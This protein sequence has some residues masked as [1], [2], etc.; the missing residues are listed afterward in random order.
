[1]AKF[2]R[3]STLAQKTH[4]A[5]VPLFDTCQSQIAGMLIGEAEN[6]ADSLEAAEWPPFCIASEENTP[7]PFHDAQ[8]IAFESERRIIALIAGSQGGKTAWGPWW[9]K[10][11]I[12]RRGKGDYI[13]AT[14]SYDLFKLKML[15]EFLRVFEEIL[16]LGRFWAGDKVFELK[17]PE[18]GRY[19]ANKS[20]D[21][22]WGRVIL[23]SANAVGGLESATVKGM[24]LDEAGQDD[25][26]IDAWH[27][28]RRRGTIHQAR[29]LITT[30]LYN[31]GWLKQQVIDRAVQNG[32][33]TMTEVGGG[34]IEV[35]DNEQA[36]ICLTQFD[37]IVNPQFPISE[38]ESARDTMPDD[39]F[40]MFY[41]GRV[42]SMRY[43]IYDCFDTKKHLCPRFAIPDE[44]PR[45][46]GLDF[47]GANTAG[48]FL[49]EEPGTGRLYAYREYFA[50]HKT[51]AGHAKDLREG[52]PMTPI[53][54]GG[55]KSEGQWRDEFAA[56]GI[57]NGERVAGLPV[58][59]TGVTDVQVG[60]QRVYGA[61]KNDGLVIFDDLAGLRDD[62]GRYRYKRDKQGNVT[63]EIEG[64][65]TF[66][67]ADALRYIVSYMP[68]NRNKSRFRSDG[69]GVVMVGTQRAGQWHMGE[70]DRER[71]I[72]DLVRDMSRPRIMG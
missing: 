48:V 44:W 55:S 29:V 37:S 47:G 14:A 68:E 46:L 8:R 42:A 64:K 67:H 70:D 6:G 50:G 9:L 13:A 32:H 7:L 63:S 15:P 20:T 54:V 71:R 23:R 38:F 17:D 36:D 41:R 31:L 3:H 43:L 28:L 59:E 52:E 4:P 65:A 24:W 5:G 35:T 2:P 45:Y 10:R 60:I 58:K 61:F 12:D 16:Q 21:R 57:V 72:S 22:M 40:Q 49:A 66:H 33:V 19:L 27:A 11:E 18:T 56:G 25:F 30:T 53:C 39:E 1:M 26:T 34:S 69:I 62:L 51:A